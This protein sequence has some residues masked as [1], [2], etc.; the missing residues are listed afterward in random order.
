MGVFYVV[1]FR[2]KQVDK[3][4]ELIW[5][6]GINEDKVIDQDQIFQITPRFDI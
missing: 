1:K 3:F 2:S 5:Q 4:K 6:Y